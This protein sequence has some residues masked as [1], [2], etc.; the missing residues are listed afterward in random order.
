MVLFFFSIHFH[1]CFTTVLV[2]IDVSL[3][4]AQYFADCIYKEKK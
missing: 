3:Q 2:K 4:V 1:F